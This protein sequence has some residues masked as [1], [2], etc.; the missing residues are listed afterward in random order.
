MKKKTGN[1]RLEIWLLL[2]N[3]MSL[4]T[5]MRF[6]LYSSTVTGR[7]TVGTLRKCVCV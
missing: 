1:I 7:N 3:L 2:Y 6:V 5:L 4:A